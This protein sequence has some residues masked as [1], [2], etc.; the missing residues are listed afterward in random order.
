MTLE[1]VEVH[2]IAAERVQWVARDH[3]GEAVDAF[4]RAF[5]RERLPLGGC[6]ISGRSHRIPSGL[7]RQDGSACQDTKAV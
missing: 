2:A 1:V 3:S 7:D 4:D 6:Q 5:A